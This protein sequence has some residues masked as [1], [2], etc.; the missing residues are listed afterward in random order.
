MSD[1]TI[2]HFNVCLKRFRIIAKNPQNNTNPKIII[3]GDIAVR[4]TLKKA[5]DFPNAEKSY[6]WNMQSNETII[7]ELP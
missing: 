4:N 6:P 3:I 2:F 5:T 1:T 7:P